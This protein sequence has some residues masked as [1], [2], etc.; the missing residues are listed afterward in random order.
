MKNSKG[1]WVPLTCALLIAGCA[2]VAVERGSHESAT[3]VAV[4]VATTSA[5]TGAG[6][7]LAERL[8]ARYEDVRSTCT[9]GN[10]AYFCSGVIYR[11]VIW[12]SPYYFWNNKVDP[13]YTGVSFSYLRKDVGIRRSFQDQGYVFGPADD[14]AR[15]GAPVLEMY[16]SFAFDGYTGAQRGIHG[17][18]AH[19]GLKDSGPC[20][21]QGI[22][23]VEAFAAHYLS[24]GSNYVARQT[25][26]CAFGVDARA[27]QLSIHA[28]KGGLLEEDEWQRY[29]EQVIGTWPQDI[30]QKL[31]IE[32]LYVFVEGRAPT[33]ASLRQARAMQA[34]FFVQAG[35]LLPIL[36]M[37]TSL[38]DPPFSFHAEDQGT[39]DDAASRRIAARKTT[40]PGTPVTLHD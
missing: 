11:G 3:P 2:Q 1:W 36:R 17:C 9:D 28:R 7:A 25:H 19:R 5:A 26:Q 4:S 37:T 35:R 16:C 13:N 34:D 24:G 12:A 6:E 10:A 39:P 33:S 40:G 27:F 8:N 20:G 22:E 32:A 38:S 31:P 15:A 23:T 14:W 30:P 21:E 18:G 29:T